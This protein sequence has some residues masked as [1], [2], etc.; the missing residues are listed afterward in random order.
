MSAPAAPATVPA[1]EP[2]LAPAPAPAPAPA[3]A[4]AHASTGP[5]NDHDIEDWK[6]RVNEVLAK[7]GDVVKSKSPE[8]AGGWNNSFFGCFNPIDL[9]LITWCLPCVTFGKTHHRVRKDPKLQGYEP[10][11]TSCLLL[12]GSACVG[13]HWIPMSMQR[14]DIR[15]KYNLEGTCIT[16]IAAAC[17]CGL[18]DLVQQDKEAEY[19]ESLVSETALKQPY[20][21]TGGMVYP[22]GQ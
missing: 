21:S 1:A 11:N 22:G 2:A 4:P 15:S 13:L 19:R 10:I 20:E 8:S 18:C 14:A 12:C 9:C 16:D 3:Q 7:P 5:I 17:C 6:R